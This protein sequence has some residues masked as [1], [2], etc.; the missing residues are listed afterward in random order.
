VHYLKKKFPVENTF[1][2]DVQYLNPSNEYR[3][4]TKSTGA[5]TIIAMTLAN[6]LKGKI[7]T[8]FGTFEEI[9]SESLADKIRLQWQVYQIDNCVDNSCQFKKNGC[10]PCFIVIMIDFWN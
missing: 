2:Q 7:R 8:C 6:I 10:S 5:I 4:S 9:S 1:I 3:F